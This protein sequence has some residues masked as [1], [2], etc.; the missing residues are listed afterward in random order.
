[1]QPLKD[2][3]RLSIGSPLLL[4]QSACMHGSAVLARKKHRRLTPETA[5]LIQAC[6]AFQSFLHNH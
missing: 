4:G 2:S 3:L 5:V 1:M 6:T